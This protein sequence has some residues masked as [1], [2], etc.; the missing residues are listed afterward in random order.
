M[1]SFKVQAVNMPQT[2]GHVKY[3]FGDIAAAG[4]YTYDWRVPKDALVDEVVVVVSEA[5]DHG[6]AATVKVG[7]IADDDKFL[8]TAA[9]NIKT[10]GRKVSTAATSMKAITPFTGGA[11]GDNEYIVRATITTAGANATQGEMHIF[12]NYRFN[13]NSAYVT[14]TYGETSVT[15]A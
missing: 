15:E 13:P 3:V 14:K 4:T 2:S 7:D 1:D 6:G 12:F 9:A 10:A 5:F 8:T 11:T